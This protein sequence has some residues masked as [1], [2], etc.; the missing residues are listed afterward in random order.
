MKSMMNS[1]GLGRRRNGLDALD[2]DLQAVSF[3]CADLALGSKSRYSGTHPNHN[4]NLVWDAKVGFLRG[5]PML[6][7]ARCKHKHEDW[8]AVSFACA[9]LASGSESK[10][11]VSRTNPNHITNLAWDAKVNFSG[12]P[13]PTRMRS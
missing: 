7:L 3:A 10:Y 13:Y 6:A 2:C 12:L 9:D 4:T 11:L 8:Q 1:W 5:L